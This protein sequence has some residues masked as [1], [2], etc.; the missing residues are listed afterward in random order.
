LLFAIHLVTACARHPSTTTDATDASDAFGFD[1][2]LGTDRGPISTDGAPT[3]DDAGT[4]P[5]GASAPFAIWTHHVDNERTGA[6]LR[7]TV[8]TTANVRPDHFGLVASR[9]VDGQIYT[10]PLYLSGVVDAT[11]TTRNLV[12]TATMHNTVYAFDADDPAVAAPV[13]SVSLGPS[14]P[15][16]L[17]DNCQDI[18]PEVGVLGTPVIDVATGT[19]YV[20]AKTLDPDGVHFRLHALDVGTGAEKFGGPVNIE[21][22]LPGTGNGTDPA[23]PTLRFTP[24]IQ[25][26][27][28][29]L[30]L[31]GGHVFIGFGGWCDRDVFHGWVLAYDATTLQRTAAYSSTRNGFAGGI[32]QSGSGFAADPSGDLYI[33][34]GDGAFHA[35]MSPPDLGDSVV[36]LHLGDGTLEAVDWFTPHNQADLEVRDFDL[37]CTGALLI[38][39]TNF[40]LT[41]SKQG[42]FYLL[43]R[44]AMGRFDPNDAQIVQSFAATGSLEYNHIHGAP[45]YWNGPAGETVYVWPEADVLRVYRFA[46]GRVD[47]MPVYVGTEPAPDA[48]PGGFMALSANGNAAG[49]GI[50]WSAMQLAVD[51]N[52]A[53][54]P[55]VVR[56]LDA[57]DPS[58]ELWNSEMNAAR[59]RLGNFAKFAPP[60]VANGRLYVPTFSNRLQVYGLL[61]GS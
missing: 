37:G 55:G 51:P 40:V 33:T 50:L 26:Q 21:A 53:L 9:E 38:P 12:F 56:A 59:D 47:P 18:Q 23:D 32:W 42:M 11:H 46:S 41:G 16:T 3:N 30:T 34:T 19:L 17:N 15:S 1:V 39:G 43:D 48:T 54:R 28:T 49:S 10:Q 4:P 20:V 58:H 45:V 7:E 36:R 13:W 6:N 27:R 2:P 44:N 14:V 52:P 57:T 25:L 60:I 29:A 24:L 8:L 61:P 5:D 31:V 22:S 35:D